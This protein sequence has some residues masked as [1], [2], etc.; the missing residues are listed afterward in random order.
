M[1]TVHEIH[2]RRRNSG[3]ARPVEPGAVGRTAVRL[4]AGYL[5]AAGV[6]E[7]GCVVPSLSLLSGR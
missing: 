7:L 6:A 3:M 4:N 5:I 2:G 1:S